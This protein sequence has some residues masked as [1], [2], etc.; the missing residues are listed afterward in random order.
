M[1]NKDIMVSV[2]MTCY[3]Q[4]KFVAR[5]IE[6]VLMQKVNFRYELVIAEDCSTDRTREIVKEYAEKWPH[7]IRLILQEHNVGLKA[8]SLQLKKE[9]KGKYRAHIEGDDYW[10]DENKLQ[11]Q[12]DFLEENKEYV[13]VSG[14]VICVNEKNE[15]CEFVYGDL[16]SVYSFKKE[17]DEQD[18]Q[19]WLLPSHVGAIT[20]RN[21]F[22][23]ISDETLDRYESYDVPGDRKTTLLLLSFGKIRIFPD[24]FYARR[25]N[26]A[27]PDNFTRNLIAS[28]KYLRV[29][30]W[31]DELKKMG[32]E[33][34]AMDLD[35]T[36]AKRQQWEWAVEDF[37]RE[38]SIRH[39]R[40]ISNLWLRS[41]EKYGYIKWVNKKL[42]NKLWK[43][44]KR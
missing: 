7:I 23:D 24:V 19:R 32:S 44:L 36:A 27:S 10:L 41:D 9:L 39:M 29:V 35:F 31:M 17:F 20:Y 15:E 12:V 1:V 34:F 6:S 18:F 22:A 28:D 13:A 42:M 11:K 33:M 8:Q 25:M 37:K 30:K 21:I 2:G 14:K 3:N 5:A 4:E 43:R 26:V 16:N 38:H 40:E